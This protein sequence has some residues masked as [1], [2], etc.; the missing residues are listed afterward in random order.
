MTT[1][2]IDWCW[3]VAIKRN[4][5]LEFFFLM[6]VYLRWWLFI[7]ISDLCTWVAAH[8]SII[9]G[10]LQ[11]L[12]ANTIIIVLRTFSSVSSGWFAIIVKHFF[13][14]TLSLCWFV[15]SQDWLVIEFLIAIS[16][17]FLNLILLYLTNLSVLE[18]SVHG[19]ISYTLTILFI[20]CWVNWLSLAHLSFFLCW[21]LLF[22]DTPFSESFIL[23]NFFLASELFSLFLSLL[24]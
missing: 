15:I 19:Y 5:A 1:F 12:Q 22:L 13:I 20:S 24:S 10:I 3:I 18:K 11:I 14:L 6:L 7:H 4:L 8:F 17:Y 21:L 23:V 2:N 16:V 9:S